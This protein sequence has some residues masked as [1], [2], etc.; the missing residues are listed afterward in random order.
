[1]TKPAAKERPVLFSGQMVKAIIDG[2]KV[3]T[4]RIVKDEKLK[5]F[6]GD[7]N[8]K[9]GY[10]AFTPDGYISVRGSS[11]VND[12]V[13]EVRH[14][15]ES[16]IKCPYGNI[17]DILYVREDHYKWGMWLTNGKTKLGN[18][19]WKFK[20][21]GNEV[22]FDHNKPSSFLKSRSKV[23][24]ELCFWY[25]RLGRFMPKSDA[26]IWLEIT[27]IKVERLRDISQEDAKMEG[28]VPCP[29]RPSSTDCK[30]HADGSLKRDCYVCA[31]KVLWNSINGTQGHG[32]NVN[33][34]VWCIS[35]ILLPK[36]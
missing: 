3:M 34:W 9:F 20:A 24:P 7:I 12:G 35:F 30:K 8:I 14:I 31:F 19:K 4:R 29:H 5:A 10:T 17:G 1:M 6:A 18:Q 32:W 22:L 15:G 2:N 11:S 28:V 27:N 21:M 16:F 13:K 26:R 33:D 23:A 25:K 36:K